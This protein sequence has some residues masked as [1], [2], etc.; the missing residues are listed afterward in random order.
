[1]NLVILNLEARAVKLIDWRGKMVRK[2]VIAVFILSV[3]AA[4][5]LAVEKNKTKDLP[6]RYKKWL[7]EEVPYIILPVEKD[8]FLQLE[9]D[10]ER[11]MFIEAFW[12]HRDPTQGT[13]LNEFK[14]EHYRRIQYANYNHGRSTPKPGWKTDRGRTYIVLG[15]PRDIERINEAGVYNTEVWFYQGLTQ[16]GLPSGFSVVFFQKDGVGE[17]VLYSPTMDG[18][19][20]LMTNYMGDRAD[21][22]AAFRELREINPQLANVSMSLIPGESAAMGRPSLSSDILLQQMYTVPQKQFEDK[23]AQKFL[24]YKDIVEVD[25]TANYIDSNSL[26]KLAR[27]VSGDFFVHYIIE[28][29]RF[30]VEQFE[31]KFVTHLKINGTI[32]DEEGRTIH[33]YE[34]AV[35]VEF[36]KEQLQRIAYLPFA[37]YD[38]FPLI[39][40]SY[41][42]SVLLKNESSK[43]FTSIERDIVVPEEVN[44]PFL[45]AMVLGYNAQAD[46]NENL[47]PFKF[48]KQRI[49]C[50]PS[51]V[52]HHTENLHLGFQLLGLSREL[53]RRATLVYEIL[54]EDQPVL[55]VSRKVMDY[56]DLLSIQEQFPLQEYSPAHYQLVVRLMDGDQEILSGKE[57]FEITPTKGVPR[58]WAHSTSLY[59]PSHPSYSL[60]KG[61]Q[62]FNKGEIVKA[63]IELENAYSRQPNAEHIALPLANVYMALREPA[64]VIAILELFADTEDAKYETLFFLGK[65]HQALGQYTEAI[66]LF[67]KAISS[68]GINIYLLNALGECYS[69]LGNTAEALAAWEKSLE[70]KPDQTDIQEKVNALKEK[71][72]L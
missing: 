59:P 55:T 11:D 54:K 5:L 66:A 44:A 70:I 16:Y 43:E 62:Y 51:R 30:S 47:K 61:R 1:M 14:D 22:L 67:D 6:E 34:R 3:F 60:T 38:I 27:D 69:T 72:N 4:F 35:P 49:Y 29:N 71:D 57:H 39:P 10:R 19:Q 41:K 42:F 68:H 45:S 23:Y 20:A 36:N 65:A 32:S 25:Y 2:V 40:G 63:R 9:T 18:P 12:K 33:Q 21:Y 56:P 24:L 64:R 52:Y 48:G 7:E 31:D 13:P 15:E 17:Y 58:P 50:Q 46:I 28:L 53:R 26:V 37:F 8:V